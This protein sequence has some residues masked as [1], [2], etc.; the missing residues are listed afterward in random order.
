M[1]IKADIIA[2]IQAVADATGNANLRISLGA[3]GDHVENVIGETQPTGAAWSPEPRTWP[4]II[5]GLAGWLGEPRFS[6]RQ[7]LVSGPI[8]ADDDVVEFAAPALDAVLPAANS[9]PQGR[10]VVLKEV[11]GD[12]V[13]A[14]STAGADTID[15]A[16]GAVAL[17][18]R[19]V[20]RLYSDGASD[21]RVW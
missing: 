19:G 6:V 5:E 10:R 21:W 15:G 9:V 16:V 20:L 3:P 17:G 18:A 2:A 8:T 12:P 1:S 4:V 13:S 14:V 7:L 11:V